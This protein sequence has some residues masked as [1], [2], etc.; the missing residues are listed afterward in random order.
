MYILIKSTIPC[1][2]TGEC[3]GTVSAILE[4]V[5]VDALLAHVALRSWESAW[6]RGWHGVGFHGHGEGRG[7]GVL[8]LGL[9]LGLLQVCLLLLLLGQSGGRRLTG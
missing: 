2:Q 4:G 6:C 7:G 8:R 3:I 9:E 1:T 5:D